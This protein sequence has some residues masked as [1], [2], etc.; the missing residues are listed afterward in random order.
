MLNSNLQPRVSIEGE[1]KIYKW[2]ADLLPALKYEELGGSERSRYP[3]IILAP[4]RFELDGV[5]GDMSSWENFGKWYGG[6]AKNSL[7]LDEEKKVFF[8]KFRVK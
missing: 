3:M 6:L 8:R 7:N 1:N 5:E 2:T 4:N